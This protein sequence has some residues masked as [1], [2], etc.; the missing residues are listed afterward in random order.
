MTAAR[1]SG[2]ETAGP[3]PD[4][5]RVFADF[6]RD[7]HDDPGA[8]WET[9]TSTWNWAAPLPTAVPGD[10]S[11]QGPLARPVQGGF[12]LSG[13]WRL[14]SRRWPRRWLALRL[15]GVRGAGDKAAGDGPDLF[16]VPARVLSPPSRRDHGRG[17]AEPSG[18]ACR[19]DDVHV[20]AGLATRS[21]GR[22]LGAEA[23]AFH[24]TAVTAMALGTAR[25]LAGAL[26]PLAPAAAAELTAV[27]HDERTSLAAALHGASRT[28]RGGPPDAEEAW[29]AR[30]GRAARVVH[31]VV[32]AAYE[33]AMPAVARDAR[34]PLAC[35]IEGGSPIL[36]HI[37]FA[38]DLR[39]P[40]TEILMRKAEH[41][42]DR[43]VSG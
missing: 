18:P 31:P 33:H 26:A 4:L 20:P 28:D 35:L 37:R 43:R 38:V 17:G 36:Q 7:G 10:E 8:A 14:P 3:D 5:G 30:I 23:A 12:A 41:G 16:V 24:W 39:R 15:T 9:F 6:E 22:A 27:L 40:A 19:L 29:A 42:D 11:A 13:Q 2:P 25:R 32:A 1:S 21:S 34:H